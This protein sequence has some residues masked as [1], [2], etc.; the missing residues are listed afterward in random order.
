M[1]RMS[2][3]LVSLF[4]ERWTQLA[5]NSNRFF[6]STK[7]G[8]S[9][10]ATC[11]TLVQRFRAFSASASKP[12][13]DSGDE[14]GNTVSPPDRREPVRSAVATTSSSS[15][16]TDASRQRPYRD[17]FRRDGRRPQRPA[18]DSVDQQKYEEARRR[19]ALELFGN[20]P[21]LAAQARDIPAGELLRMLTTYQL[22]QDHPR[23]VIQDPILPR[24]GGQE[25]GPLGIEIPEAVLSV[26][27]REFPPAVAEALELLD[28][29]FIWD[30]ESG[31][32]PRPLSELSASVYRDD[33]ESTWH[34]VDE[35]TMGADEFRPAT[36]ATGGGPARG[37][38]SAF[39]RSMAGA[40]VPRKQR[41]CPLCDHEGGKPREQAIKGA[42]RE[43][44][45][46]IKTFME[47][48]T[49][50]VLAKQHT[51]NELSASP[52]RPSVEMLQRDASA[53]LDSLIQ[54]TVRREF[55]A[56]S[57]RP[58]V[59][60]RDV[61]LLIRFVNEA[62]RIQSRRRTHCCAKHQRKLA[63]AIKLA[64]NAALISPVRRVGYDLVG[65]PV[66]D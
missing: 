48:L 57:Q 54:T 58:A 7:A 34:R 50:E 6:P 22:I 1:K 25:E 33:V 35:R 13:F 28:H 18:T 17:G 14:K 31:G 53:A 9:D 56:A 23:E 64:R 45:R 49:N 61:D 4:R 55:E 44:K 3:V 38:F 19:I 11:A 46:Q 29:S 43:R 51:Q 21:W 42:R 36:R 41:R 47:K 27:R 60:Y 65:R 8:K 39:K 5:T 16:D 24:F 37:A 66:S 63:R 20:P 2:R 30:I 26:F 52:D 10:A 59:D 15:R 32:V 40:F 62:G 12:P